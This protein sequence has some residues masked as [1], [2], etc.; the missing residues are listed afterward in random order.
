MK[1]QHTFCGLPQ[2]SCVVLLLFIVHLIDFFGSSKRKLFIQR[3]KANDTE[4]N[5]AFNASE[6]RDKTKSY[7]VSD[8]VNFYQASAQIQHSSGLRC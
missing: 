2:G 8:G 1:T 6:K 7:T 5:E 3:Y 4:Q